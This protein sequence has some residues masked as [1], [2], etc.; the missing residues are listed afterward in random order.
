M[1]YI[2]MR[3]GP[4]DSDK[5]EVFEG[6]VEMSKQ[7]NEVILVTEGS[8]KDGRPFKALSCGGLVPLSLEGKRCRVTI[9]PMED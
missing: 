1:P 2:T 5:R 6:T 7:L 8:S 3:S 9:E 4:E